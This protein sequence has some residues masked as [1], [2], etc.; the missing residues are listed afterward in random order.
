MSKFNKQQIFLIKY[1]FM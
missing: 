1:I